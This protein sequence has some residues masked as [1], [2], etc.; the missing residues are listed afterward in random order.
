M[1]GAVLSPFCELS[2]KQPV[3]STG[4]LRLR[5][6]KSLGQEHIA[7]KLWGQDSTYTCHSSPVT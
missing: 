1:A 2:G 5:E 3:L 4:K 6:M 7:R